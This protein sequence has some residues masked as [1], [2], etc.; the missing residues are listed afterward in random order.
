MNTEKDR[1]VRIRMSASAPLQRD[2]ETLEALPSATVTLAQLVDNCRR[3]MGE[4]AFFGYDAVR[5]N[6]Q[7]Y[8]DT[9][10]SVSGLN[11]PELHLFVVQDVAGILTR[12]THAVARAVTDLVGLVLTVADRALL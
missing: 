12:R 5:D 8:V 4:S 11:T 9:L 6:C 3:R 10:L 1:L 2:I 7:C